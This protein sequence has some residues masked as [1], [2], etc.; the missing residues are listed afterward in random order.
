MII[1]SSRPKNASQIYC[2]VRFVH[3]RGSTMSNWLIILAFAA[4]I[5]A[6]SLGSFQRKASHVLNTNG[7]SIAH[8]ALGTSNGLAATGGTNLAA[9]APGASPE[10]DKDRAV[11]LFI[12]GTELLTA[13]KLSNA[14]E[15]FEA[16]LKL[17]PD[18]ED[19]HYNL[20]FTL[21]RMGRTDDAIRAY[22]EALRVFP[23]Y[24][25][26][27][28]NLG[29]LLK[30]QGKLE[31]AIVE[32]NAALKINPDHS[33]AHNNL[34]V[35]LAQLGRLDEAV[36]HFS[37]A[38][39]LQSDYVDAHYNLGTAYMTLGRHAEAI[40]EFNSTLRL[41]PDFQPGMR[42][43]FRARQAQALLQPPPK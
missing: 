23:D 32:L 41:Q 15:V 26:A 16:S 13:Q 7:V 4:V 40:A 17:D 37:K 38:T 36:L 21:A 33:S 30:N 39:Q 2:T 9:P 6:L 35:A 22:R 28:N 31:E 42:A 25:E 20:A 19:T 12:T 34:G 27:H 11:R 8:Q 14:V 18:S 3:S 1:S 43:L 5:I 29:N 24:A 10:T